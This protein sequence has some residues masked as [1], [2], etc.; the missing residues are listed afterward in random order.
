MIDDHLS[1]STLDAPGDRRSV[2]AVHKIKRHDVVFTTYETLRDYQLSFG[3]I[4]WAVTVF[5]EAQKIKNPAAALTDAAK[6]MKN[7]FVVALTG[8]PVENR[9]ADLWCIVDTV[10]PGSLQTLKEFSHAYEKPSDD[11]DVKLDELYRKLT[12]DSPGVPCMMLRRLKR[13]KLDGLPEIEHAPAG[14]DNLSPCYNEGLVRFMPDAQAKAYEEAIELGRR[15]VGDGQGIL[16][17]LG[18][19]K[20]ISLHPY[21]RRDEPT[22]QYIKDSARLAATFD[23]LDSIQRLGE[24]ALIFLESRKMQKVILE[25]L[26]ER[27]RFSTQPLLINGE[28]SGEDRKARVNRFQA[29]SGFD[30]MVLS[31]KAGGVGLT[32]TAANHVIHLSRWWNPAVEDQCTDR[33]YRIGQRKGVKVYY[34]IAVH[35][36][37]GLDSFDVKLSQLLARKRSLWRKVLHPSALMDNDIDELFASTVERV[38]AEETERATARGFVLDSDADAMEPLQFERWVLEKIRDLGF[39]IDSTPRTG[40]AGADGIAMSKDLSKYPNLIIQVKH[41]QRGANLGK[42]FVEDVFRA[43]DAYKLKRPVKLVVVTNAPDF[44]EVAHEYAKSAGILC[45]SRRNIGDAAML[46]RR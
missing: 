40:D 23:L 8:T 35:P 2:V 22:G 9:L 30:V 25:M 39:V 28:V 46:L 1:R 19:L 24:K 21:E 34:P 5:D 20:T 4:D 7:S 14:F 32:L 37:I 13:E 42:E 43:K 10:Q 27:Y 36:T 15:A 29:K 18:Q 11:Q 44:T 45:L 16:Q 31:P 12:D 26:K 38:P 6:G 17:V 3:K 33:A 41:S